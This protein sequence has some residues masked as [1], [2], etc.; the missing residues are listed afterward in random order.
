MF[1]LC[2]VNNKKRVAGELA[3]CF[4]NISYSADKNN[5]RLKNNRGK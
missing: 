2:K 4:A 1:Y 5:I 3:K